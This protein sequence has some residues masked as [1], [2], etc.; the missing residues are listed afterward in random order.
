MPDKT[1]AL[2]TFCKLCPSGAT[3]PG[4]C[5]QTRFDFGRRI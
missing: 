3:L 1:I 4:T 5:V 2:K